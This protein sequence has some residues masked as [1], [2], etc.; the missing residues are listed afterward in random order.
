MADIKFSE[1]PKATTSKDSDEIAILQDGV[2]KMIP[3]PVLESKI[4]NKT[5]SRVIEQGGASLNVINLQG[6]VP[7][8]ADLAT[9]TPIPELNDAYQVE[10]DGLVYVYTETGF[11]ADGDGFN[12]LPEP[13]GIV[14]QGNTQA[15]SGG[16]VFEALRA[17]TDTANNFLVETAI[18][19]TIR[20]NG[21]NVTDEIEKKVLLKK[22]DQCFK[23][24]KCFDLAQNEFLLLRQLSYIPST[25]T[26]SLGFVV[27][28]NE[29]DMQDINA[30]PVAYIE[31]AV[32]DISKPFTFKFTQRYTG[33][34]YFVT[35]DMSVFPTETISFNFRNSQQMGSYQT[36]GIKSSAITYLDKKDIWGTGYRITTGGTNWQFPRPYYFHNAVKHI[37]VSSKEKNLVSI[38]GVSYNAA[39]GILPVIIMCCND[40]DPNNLNI[41]TS[42]NG[43]AYLRINIPI[44]DVGIK[45]YTSYVLS[46][47]STAEVTM[48]VD[49]DYLF[50]NVPNVTTS[51]FGI[52]REGE[53]A[54][55]IVSPSSGG[56]GTVNT[57][58]MID[59]EGDFQGNF[60]FVS[61]TGNW[62]L[63]AGNSMT[64]LSRIPEGTTS[65]DINMSLDG[66]NSNVMCLD[67]DMKM[68]EWAYDGANGT[69]NSLSYTPPA[70]AVFLLAST[71]T[72]PSSAKITANGT[73]ELTEEV[74]NYR[75]INEGLADKHS[76]E[77]FIVK[78][79]AFKKNAEGLCTINEY[80]VLSTDWLDDIPEY[81]KD[82]GFIIPTNVLHTDGTTTFNGGT[83]CD[84]KDGVMYFYNDRECAVFKSEDNGATFT[85]ITDKFS[86]PSIWD[87]ETLSYESRSAIIPLNNGELLIPIRIRG[88]VINPEEST[89]RYRYWTL[90]RTTGGQTDIVK[91]FEFSHESTYNRPWLP[92]S[93]PKHTWPNH[94][95]G[96]LLGKF[97]SYVY[98]DIIVV[99]E[100]GEGTSAYWNEQ[101]ISNNGRGISG[102]AWVSMDNGITWKKMFDADRKK[103][104]TLEDDSN[105]YYFTDTL[106]A[107]SRHMH[108]V[109]IDEVR[110]VVHLTNGDYEDYDWSISI[111]D[112]ATWYNSAP[113][114]D[115]DENPTYKVIDT[116]PEWQSNM[117]TTG[118]T[119]SNNAYSSMKYQMMQGRP[120]SFGNVW[121]HDASREFAY[122]SYENN[123]EYIF[124]PV[125]QFENIEDFDTE[126]AFVNSW[127]STDAFVQDITVH[128][129]VIYFTHSNRGDKP[130]R[131]YATKNGLSWKVVY[132]GDNADIKFAGKILLDGVNKY[133][134]PGTSGQESNVSGYWKLKTK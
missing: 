47:T 76:G 16:D 115:P 121:A 41:N 98:E 95:S 51:G 83:L 19:P 90:Y 107:K 55:F 118:S 28:T 67:K 112:L 40:D 33:R 123:G 96:C 89:N 126:Q 7:T 122:I 133:L 69:I 3:S 34:C 48:V 66:V 4:I 119:S 74:K 2:N 61:A 56:G 82:G 101:G 38:T 6:V 27:V 20:I 97:T 17:K 80:E 54:Q 127:S 85:V 15:V 132:E 102:R 10:A 92:E 62:A 58:S 134:S 44:A 129:G 104:G 12:L 84:V 70:E 64:K 117:L 125:F 24:I 60:R 39:G 52:E 78:N 109:H 124:E 50:G 29:Q 116:Y 25:N 5:V 65:I 9:I 110:G 100:Y 59:G 30:L 114:V 93:N 99:T 105:W 23:A 81:E 72:S 106:A 32:A 128:N 43:F 21:V 120:V 71:T 131:I 91:C 87:S 36:C 49:C 111:D 94:S 42:R 46:G 53:L 11:Q 14:E 35:M 77:V 13:T 8:Y 113:S 73:F 45:K 130:S 86:H 108:G 63:L 1:F 18:A 75:S 31:E 57:L 26:V 88:S 37:A 22:L 103:V 79:T 68:I